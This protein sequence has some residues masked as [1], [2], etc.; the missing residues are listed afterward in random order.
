MHN[1]KMI[2]IGRDRDV[3]F[4]CERCA[5]G[6]SVEVRSANG[7]TIRKYRTKQ[8][9]VCVGCG[10]AGR[11]ESTQAYRKCAECSGSGVC[12]EC[13]GEYSR[14]WNDLSI[15]AQSKGISRLQHGEDPLA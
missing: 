5:V 12:P 6:E 1:C 4:F 8:P 9:G 11:D 2:L 15:S 3:Q 7:R 13:N 10:G 14:S